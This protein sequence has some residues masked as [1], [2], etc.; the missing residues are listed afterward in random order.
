MLTSY[1]QGSNVI[2]QFTLPTHDG[3]TVTP[4]AVEW[5]LEDQDGVELRARGALSGWTSGNPKVEV[6]ANLNEL[7]TGEDR[8][9]RTVTVYITTAA[10]GEFTLT[11]RYVIQDADALTPLVNSFQSYNQAELTRFE[12][13]VLD[14]WD[15]GTNQQRT[16]AMIQAYRA[17]C[18]LKFRYK[19]TE[20]AQSQ[21]QY[22]ASMN[23]DDWTYIEDISR[24]TQDD[25]D[26]LPLAFRKA[27]MQAQMTEAENFIS[28]NPIEDKRRDGIISETIGESKMFFNNRPPLQLPVSRKTL[29]ILAGYYYLRYRIARA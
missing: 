16:A 26:A 19:S 20:L 5:S 27:L 6:P 21:I 22:D 15:A 8:A 3:A 9:L 10:D 25:W 29:D 17:I 12:L 24:L 1:N 2:V 28:G 4:S 14:G 18:R 7:D 13:P 11:E 23:L